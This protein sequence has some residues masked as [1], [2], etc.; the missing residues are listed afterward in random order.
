MRRS[1]PLPLDGRICW[2]PL[3]DRS[4]LALER[5]WLGAPDPAEALIDC[6]QV[7]PPLLLWAV[8]CRWRDA[9]QWGPTAR[10]TADWL[11]GHLPELLG[12]PVACE[13]REDGAAIAAQVEQDLLLAEVA[14]ALAA[15]QDPAQAEAARFLGPVPHGP[16]WLALLGC[17]GEIGRAHV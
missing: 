5:V 6:L 8:W 13:S 9:R 15:E 14:H 1:L 2:F 17:S 7:D 4:A 16:Q 11:Q 3:A 10:E 12:Q